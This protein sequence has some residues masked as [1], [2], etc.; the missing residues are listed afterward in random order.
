MDWKDKI[1]GSFGTVGK[2]F[3][4][5]AYDCERALELLITAN[6]ADIGYEEYLAEIENWLKSVGCSTDHIQREMEKVKDVRY[7]LKN[8]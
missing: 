6:K 1:P 5:H 8:D 3:A 7:Y 2:N 4:S